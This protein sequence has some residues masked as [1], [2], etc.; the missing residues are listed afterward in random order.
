MGQPWSSERGAE[1]GRALPTPDVETLVRLLRAPAR[2]F[3]SETWRE[4]VTWWPPDRRRATVAAV[5]VVLV[6]ALVAWRV[7]APDGAVSV[8]LPRVGA[9]S[10]GAT[11]SPPTTVSVSSPAVTT[12]PEGTVP[13][14]VT[15]HVAGAVLTPGVVRVAGTARWGDAVAAAGGA[16]ADA[17][18]D[19]V[20]LA[21]P[22]VDGARLLVPRRG[23]EP[24][25]VVAADVVSDGSL[26]PHA[27]ATRPAVGSRAAATRR[28]ADRRDRI[29]MSAPPGSGRVIIARCTRA[30]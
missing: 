17:D 5:V 13:V 27:V 19:R 28:R 16:A 9:P 21:A 11:A 23:S 18:L 10:G 4:R 8:E 7:W 30:A 6:G 29:T 15:L 3:W 24:P 14:E 1:P 12:V 26:P 20:N 22:V 25:S 2:P